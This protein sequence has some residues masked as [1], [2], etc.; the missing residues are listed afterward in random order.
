MNEDYK[1]FAERMGSFDMN[2]DFPDDSLKHFGVK[3]MKWGVRKNREVT[4]GK[5]TPK[6]DGTI[7]TAIKSNLKSM[8]R[9]RQWRKELQ[10]V[11]KMSNSEINKLTNRIRLENDLKRLSKSK[12]ANSDDK[13]SYL[14]RA[15]MTD[16]ELNETVTRLRFK[17]NLSRVTSDATRSQVEAGKKAVMIAATIG[18]K[19]ATSGVVDTKDIGKALLNPKG[20]YSGTKDGL[21]NKAFDKTNKR[22]LT[23][24]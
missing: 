13:K 18:I 1:N 24:R 8:S 15:K 2:F 17:D 12:L 7:K 10:N 4:G 19:Y 23:R 14:N 3:G 6:A 9:E 20:A 11:D 16:K 21:I 5:K 22:V